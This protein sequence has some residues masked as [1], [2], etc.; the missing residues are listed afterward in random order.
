[1]SN[2]TLTIGG[3]EFI[4]ASAE[5]EEAHIAMLGRMIDDRLRAMGAAAAGQNEAR[6]L[7]FAALVLADDLYEAQKGGAAAPSGDASRIAERIGAIADR[8]EK[9]ASHLEEAGST[10]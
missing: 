7:L 2:V 9:L 6:M 1:M 5:G 8:I 3:R 4:V 10:P